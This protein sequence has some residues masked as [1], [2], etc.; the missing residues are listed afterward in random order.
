M[1][2]HQGGGGEWFLDIQKGSF[3]PPLSPPYAHVW[4]IP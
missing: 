2:V 1:E 4:L 3:P